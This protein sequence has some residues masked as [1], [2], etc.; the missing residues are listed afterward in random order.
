LR[1]QVD[2][3][4]SIVVSGVAGQ[5]GIIAIKNVNISKRK[6]SSTAKNESSTAAITGPKLKIN[7]LHRKLIPLILLNLSFGIIVGMID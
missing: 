5:R 6:I 2:S 4:S 7:P 1:V 3:S